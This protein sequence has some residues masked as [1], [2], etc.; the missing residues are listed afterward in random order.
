MSTSKK[1]IVTAGAMIVIAFLL[2]LRAY[3]IT[4]STDSWDLWDVLS[5]AIQP[6]ELILAACIAVI[7]SIFTDGRKET[8]G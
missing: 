3:A 5:D 6:H 8:N 4:P 7:A 1:L 2:S